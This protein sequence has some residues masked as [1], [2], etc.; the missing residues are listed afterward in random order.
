MGSSAHQQDSDSFFFQ[1]KI[2]I[3]SIFAISPLHISIVFL[4]SLI[5]VFP[6]SAVLPV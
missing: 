6:V 4:N 1:K 5:S 2:W 3:Q